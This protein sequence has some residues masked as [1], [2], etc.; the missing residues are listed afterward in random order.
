MIPVLVTIVVVKASHVISKPEVDTVADKG[1][2][3]AALLRTHPVTSMIMPI[4]I[5]VN[6]SF[7]G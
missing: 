7:V 2:A 1:M 6:H 3:E 5:S 4:I